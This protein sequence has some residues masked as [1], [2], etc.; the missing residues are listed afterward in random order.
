MDLTLALTMLHRTPAV[1][2]ALLADLPEDWASVNE[3]PD[4]WS[5]YDVVGHLID[6]ERTDW[7]ARVRIILSDQGER[8]FETFDR[9][10]HLRESPR[11][12]LADRLATFAALRQENL[13][14]LEALH[15]AA[16]DLA[17]TAT[18]PELGTVTLRELLSTWVAHDLDHVSQI[19]RV[20]ATP[21]AGDVGPWRAYLRV[22]RDEACASEARRRFTTSS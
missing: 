11:P 9:F 20:L 10:R 7:L 15:L 21:L 5:P 2:D 12:S 6:G 8:A 16:P 3:G 19:V 18:H 13:A 1:L 22:V 17:R 14:A 4:T